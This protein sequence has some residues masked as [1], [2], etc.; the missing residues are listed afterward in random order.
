MTPYDDQ[1]S[2]SIIWR[3]LGHR[4]ELGFKGIVDKADTLGWLPPCSSESRSPRGGHRGLC[5]G[6]NTTTS[7][8]SHRLP[9]SGHAGLSV[10]CERARQ[11]P[12]PPPHPPQSCS[13]GNS[14]PPEHHVATPSG[15]APPVSIVPLA[16][17]PSMP[18][19]PSI[20]YFLTYSLRLLLCLL[21]VFHWTRLSV[22]RAGTFVLGSVKINKEISTKIGAG[23]ACKENSLPFIIN[24]PKQE[25]TY[26]SFPTRS[27][28]YRLPLQEEDFLLAQQQAQPIKYTAAQPMRSHHHPELLLSSNDLSF[29]IYCC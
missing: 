15:P 9:R 12:P 20:Y 24:H 5:L 23:T 2:R 6:C 25:E 4:E 16:P 27:C 18:C 1:I 21:V 22:L 17:H 26:L 11:A 28:V 13:A 29:F 10:L 3:G 14:P 8:A 7:L 19:H